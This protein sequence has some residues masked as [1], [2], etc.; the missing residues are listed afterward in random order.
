MPP[1]RE[2]REEI[3]LLT[4]YF[5]KKYSVQYNKPY[6]ELSPGNDAAC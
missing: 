6:V 2:R 4:D 3:P 1:L 5:L